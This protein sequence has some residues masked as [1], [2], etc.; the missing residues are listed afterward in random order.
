[1]RR[2]AA[3]RRPATPS[4]L[5]LTFAPHAVAWHVRREIAP[6]VL[7]PQATDDGTSWL[8]I[9]LERQ[10]RQLGG[11]TSAP[12]RTNTEEA[13]AKGGHAV[14]MQTGG[15]LRGLDGRADVG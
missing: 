13:S 6:L 10:R 5:Y 12:Y 8:V 2:W 7:R 15:W 4:H 14:E 9:S 3:Q 11:N 1:M